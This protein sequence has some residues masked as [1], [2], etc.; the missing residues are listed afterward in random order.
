LHTTIKKRAIKEPGINP[1]FYFITN[2]NASIIKKD[3]IPSTDPRARIALVIDF[4]ISTQS[5]Q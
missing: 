4:I 3:N 2:I 5:P 1:G